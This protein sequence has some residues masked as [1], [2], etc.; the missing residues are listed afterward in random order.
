MTPGTDE[1]TPWHKHMRNRKNGNSAYF[2]NM[3]QAFQRPRRRG[4]HHRLKFRNSI[5]VR[6]ICPGTLG[7]FAANFLEFTEGFCKDRDSWTFQ[8]APDECCLVMSPRSVL[9]RKRMPERE[10]LRRV[11]IAEIEFFEF[12]P[13]RIL[14]AEPSRPP[15]CGSPGNCVANLGPCAADGEKGR[16]A[17]R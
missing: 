3:K 5:F 13:W 11:H 16:E 6:R 15:S 2:S 7:I 9:R 8:K 12:P 1:P 14:Y 4:V 17:S 10:A